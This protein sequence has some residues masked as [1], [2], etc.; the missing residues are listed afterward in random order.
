MTRAA[1]AIIQDF[2]G[3]ASAFSYY[4][5]CSTGGAEAME[6]AEF[7]PRDYDGIHAGSPGMD[8]S[9]FMESFLGA[10]CYPPKIPPPP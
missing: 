2:Y 5:G 9:H 3:Q 6:E 7:Y 1:Q 4:E 8:Y 10:R